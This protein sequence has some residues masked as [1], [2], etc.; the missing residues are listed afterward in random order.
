MA[1]G[2]FKDLARTASDKVLRDIAFNITNNPKYDEYQR[3]FTSMVY[4]L[5]DKDFSGSGIKSMVNQQ[6]SDEIHK[7]VIKNVKRRKVYSSFKDNIRGADL[8]DMQLIRKY[9][10]RIGLLL[11]VIDIFSKYAWVFLLKDKKGIT[12]VDVF[13]KIL[14]NSKRRPKYVKKAKLVDKGREF[15][16]SFFKKW[17]K[18]NDTEMYSAYNE[19]KSV[20]VE[21][22]FKN[23]KNK[24]YNL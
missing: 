8:A 5:F 1:F 14:N 19:G 6:L 22:L 24:I 7:P 12:I 9:N 18:D 17:L 20:A 3:R 21:K 16:K 11:H 10:K 15:Y 23:L 2:D 13:Q 4:K